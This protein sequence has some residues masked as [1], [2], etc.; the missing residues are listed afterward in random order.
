MS[1][2]LNFEAEPY[3]GFSGSHRGSAEEFEAVV[4]DHRTAGAPVIGGQ[5]GGYAVGTVVR[6]HR[7]TYG[8]ATVTVRP[9]GGATAIS[10][11]TNWPGG[12][13]AW[14]DWRGWGGR[15]PWGGW[16]GRGA[17]SGLGPGSDWS[18]RRDYWQYGSP[19]YFGWLNRRGGEYY[20]AA[21][22]Y[23]SRYWQRWPWLQGASGF[24]PTPIVSGS[25]P[26]PIEAPAADPQIVAWAQT[27][28]AQVVG[29]WVPQD[30]SLG[31]TTQRAIQ[32]FQTQMNLPPSG[33]LDD[34]TLIALQQACQAQA[35]AAAA[36][37]PDPQG[38]VT[39]SPS[40]EPPSPSGGA[41]ASQTEV[42]DFPH[43]FGEAEN[44]MYEMEQPRST[45]RNLI[46]FQIPEAPYS[47]E[48][49]KRI[50]KGIDIVDAIHTAME[51]FEVE[52]PGLLGL[53]VTAIAPLIAWVGTFFALGEGY[54]EAR[55]I[56]S[57]RRIRSGFTLGVVMGA[58]HRKW[59]EI[60][61]MFWEYGPE[62]NN[63]DPDAGRIAQ[64]AFNTGL[65][66]GFL[67]GREIAEAP[68]KKKF[69]WSSIAASLTPGDRNEFAGDTKS[70]PELTWR[71]W[72]ITA[73]AK[74]SNLYLQ[75]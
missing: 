9:P 4:R 26:S 65:A 22:Q 50:H 32:I 43:E 70:W 72:Y 27:C 64:K 5:R 1:A 15:G 56:I 74:F 2:D 31:G 42:F 16:V 11:R 3:G 19:H 10:A 24:A 46:V 41:P 21:W 7:G 38:G 33:A 44:A 40:S 71:N 18:R 66:T 54:A 35:A 20:P 47:D 69:F 51:I 23:R 55:A 52:L 17:W 67:Q 68:R 37:A 28:L 49:F 57:R 25:A 59:P 58:D 29:P 12:R 62:I 39:V 48:T 61:H 45:R 73:A 30:G 34:N 14:R 75:D 6:D 8:G 36:G 13:A 60:K 53:G 63:F